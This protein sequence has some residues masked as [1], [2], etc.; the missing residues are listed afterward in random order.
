MFVLIFTHMV[1]DG[2]GTLQTGHHLLYISV[3]L[4]RGA[5]QQHANVEKMVPR[6]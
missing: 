4:R 3:L 6:L 2:I 1:V 5:P